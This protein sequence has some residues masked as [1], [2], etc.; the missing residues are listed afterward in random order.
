L[1]YGGGSEDDPNPGWLLSVNIIGAI[2]IIVWSTV[3]S[4][5]IFAPLKYLGKYRIDRETEFKGNDSVKHGESAYPRD[6]WVELQVSSH[7]KY[8]TLTWALAWVLLS[9]S[10]VAALNVPLFRS[11]RCGR[12]RTSRAT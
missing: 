6:A 5:L 10:R 7:I 2:A 11:T 1:F 8:F 3:L 4:L 12:A 9:L